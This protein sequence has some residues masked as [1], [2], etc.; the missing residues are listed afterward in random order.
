[1]CHAPIGFP[2]CV[3]L[4]PLILK[5]SIVPPE[6]E[7]YEFSVINSMLRISYFRKFQL[8]SFYFRNFQMFNSSKFVLSVIRFP[9]LQF[10]YLQFLIVGVSSVHFSESW[11]SKFRALYLFRIWDDRI[12]YFLNLQYLKFNLRGFEF[13]NDQFTKIRKHYFLSPTL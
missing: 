5:L 6:S 13:P 4:V 7:M 2:R 9:N 1:M 3:R 12:S 11:L 10:L 8:T